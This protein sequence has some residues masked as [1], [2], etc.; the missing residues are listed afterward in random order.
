MDK[1]EAER[2]VQ[3]AVRLA[4]RLVKHRLSLMG[5]VTTT[6]QEQRIARLRSLVHRAALRVGRRLMR[7]ETIK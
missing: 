1:D 6:T 3:Q 4:S 5:D 2:L 7:A